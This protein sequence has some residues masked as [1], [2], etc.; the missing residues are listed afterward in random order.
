M[1]HD[2]ILKSELEYDLRIFE[3][4]QQEQ[5]LRQQM[6]N[7]RKEMLQAEETAMMALQ[8]QFLDDTLAS[9]RTP[10]EKDTTLAAGSNANT[11]PCKLRFLSNSA[12]NSK[13]DG[14]LNMSSANGTKTSSMK[15]RNSIGAASTNM[16]HS[17]GSRPGSYNVSPCPPTLKKGL[18][19]CSN[20]NSKSSTPKILSNAKISHLHAHSTLTPNSLLKAVGSALRVKD[21]TPY[22]V[23]LDEQTE[24]ADDTLHLSR[25]SA[26]N[27]GYDLELGGELGVDTELESPLGLV[28]LDVDLDMHLATKR[29]SFAK[30]QSTSTRRLSWN[31]DVG[32][33]NDSDRETDRAA[34][35]GKDEAS[36]NPKRLNR[37]RKAAPVSADNQKPV[38]TANEDATVPTNPDGR[39]GR[40]TRNRTNATT[41]SLMNC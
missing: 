3:Q 13:S 4:A 15:P 8:E 14:L 5:L 41:N 1:S 39:S 27:P 21:S 19:T 37:K 20:T 6:L 29:D 24:R 10:I 38:R 2:P 28:G 17:L 33:L 31:V 16:R 26:S 35:S 7:R 22:G 23:G 40:R 34:P 9:T 11:T 36:V 12:T 30:L 25:S 18:L 32:M